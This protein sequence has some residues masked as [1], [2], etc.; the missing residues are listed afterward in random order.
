MIL[1]ALTQLELPGQI[2]DRAPFGGQTGNQLLVLVLQDQPVEDVPAHGVV[3]AK[4]V[5]M[6][7]HR[8]RLGGQADGQFVGQRRH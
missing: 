6:R 4:I 5:E 1:D 3:G 7:V 2:V 8:G